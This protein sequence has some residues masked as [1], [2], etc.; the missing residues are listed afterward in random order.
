MISAPTRQKG[1]PEDMQELRRPKK[2]E[3][4][5]PRRKAAGMTQAQLAAALDVERSALSMWEIGV[6]WPSARILPAMA[7]LLLCSIDDLYVAPE[8][9]VP[10]NGRRYEDA[11]EEN[12]GKCPALREEAA[13]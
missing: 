10:T 8:E 1:E 3:G 7:D 12:A 11:P 2:L 9:D 5:A 4:L 13:P 6:N